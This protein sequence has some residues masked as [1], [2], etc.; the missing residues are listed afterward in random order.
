MKKKVQRIS[1]F[2]LFLLTPLSST[3]YFSS[4]SVALGKISSD[5]YDEKETK[6]LDQNKSGSSKNTHKEVENGRG[7]NQISNSSRDNF[8]KPPYN[9]LDGDSRYSIFQKQNPS[10]KRPN[11]LENSSK[12]PF[13]NSNLRDTE[14]EESI[15]YK[16]S[17]F[18]SD[19]EIR[20]FQQYFNVFVDTEKAVKNEQ[21]KITPIRIND[22]ILQDIESYYKFDFTIKVLKSEDD[23]LREIF[24]SL[25]RILKNL[26]QRANNNVDPID[27][28]KE[29]IFLLN[30]INNLNIKNQ[31]FDDIFPKLIYKHRYLFYL[32]TK[33]FT[34]LGNYIQYFFDGL[35]KPSIFRIL[36][37]ELEENGDHSLKIIAYLD[38]KKIG[39]LFKED[40]EPVDSN[41]QISAN[42]KFVTIKNLEY[43]KDAENLNSKEFSLVYFIPIKEKEATGEIDPSSPN[44]A[45]IDKEFK[46]FKARKKKKIDI[47]KDLLNISTSD[48]LISYFM[49]SESPITMI[50]N[51]VGYS[52]KYM[53][54]MGRLILSEKEDYYKELLY[55][56]KVI[57]DKLHRNPYFD[58]IK[59]SHVKKNIEYYVNSEKISHL[60]LC[61]DIMPSCEKF[62]IP[63]SK[64]FK[65]ALSIINLIKSL[66]Y[67]SAWISTRR[68][69]FFLNDKG[70][71]FDKSS[72][73]NSDSTDSKFIPIVSSEEDMHRLNIKIIEKDGVKYFTHEQKYRIVSNDDPRKYILSKN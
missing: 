46:N 41:F 18:S 60:K 15:F 58:S 14:R 44:P 5:G 51:G 70:L 33:K 4:L 62:T 26:I 53:E 6:R 16:I 61:Q 55:N 30:Y 65:N 35:F 9:V 3:Y 42:F 67:D 25:K 63:T 19:K 22:G 48:V 52:S 69:Y 64:E 40:F 27:Q 38:F 47:G 2:L 12:D 68:K 49:D 71:I 20:K 17:S 59:L 21:I 39:S 56:D 29:K 57:Q 72:F 11:K 66:R 50:Q 1:Q 34:G 54:L 28:N 24:S 73:E 32:F 10:I 13:N 7:N 23:N 31:I 37:L 43:E 8:Q 36:S 45:D